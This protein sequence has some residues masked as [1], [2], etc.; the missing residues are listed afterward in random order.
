MF[1]KPIVCKTTDI[2]EVG[3]ALIRRPR[4]KSSSALAAAQEQRIAKLKMEIKD[5]EQKVGDRHADAI[6]KAHIELLH[7]YNEIKDGTQALIGKYAVMTG[8][9]VR[10]IHEQMSLSLV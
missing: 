4:F 5:L 8:S 1:K 3:K 9:T 7:S 6:V 10:D 2:A